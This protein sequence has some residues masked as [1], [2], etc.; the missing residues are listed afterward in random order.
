MKSRRTVFCCAAAFYVSC[1]LSKFMLCCNQ[2]QWWQEKGAVSKTQAADSLPAPK[3]RVRQF[4]LKLPLP[5]CS[6][7]GR[8]CGPWRSPMLQYYW[9][10]LAEQFLLH[11]RSHGRSHMRTMTIK[12]ARK[13]DRL[14]VPQLE[15]SFSLDWSGKELV[16]CRHSA[17]LIVV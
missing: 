14:R 3:R 17:F 16:V 9:R 6:R 12:N 1:A 10:F 15:R 13:N 4:F 8:G 5:E 11:S 7:A 2:C